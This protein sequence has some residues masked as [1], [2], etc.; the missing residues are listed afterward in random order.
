MPSSGDEI[1]MIQ[2]L[3][4]SAIALGGIIA[5]AIGKKLAGKVDKATFAMYMNEHEKQHTERTKQHEIERKEA[6]E[7]A[8]EIKAAISSLAAKIQDR[9]STDG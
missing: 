1:G 7:D 8:K 3:A 5:G 4:G 2:W 9:R 6:R